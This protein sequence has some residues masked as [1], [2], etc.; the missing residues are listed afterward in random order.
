MSIGLIAGGAGIPLWLPTIIRNVGVKD[1]F[2]IGL[3]AAIPYVV[4]IVVQQIV[5]RHSDR[6]QER[7]WHAAIPTFACA[8]GWVL[9]AQVTDTP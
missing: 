8:L 5:A 2:T 1:T 4:A 6:T 9:L 3:L 7:R